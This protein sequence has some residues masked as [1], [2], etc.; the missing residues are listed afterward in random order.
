MFVLQHQIGLFLPMTVHWMAVFGFHGDRC[1]EGRLQWGQECGVKHTSF[2][3]FL[4]GWPKHYT[5]W[6]LQDEHCTHW[7]LKPEHW[8]LNNAHC[9]HWTHCKHCSLHMVNCTLNTVFTEKPDCSEIQECNTHQLDLLEEWSSCQEI[10]SLK[11]EEGTKGEKLAILF[12]QG[13]HF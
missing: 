9:T 6:T 4:T 7:T 2:S 3:V 10:L 11:R 5:T 12:L 13:G 8:I 1:A